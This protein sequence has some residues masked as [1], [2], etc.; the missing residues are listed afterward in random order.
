MAMVE[1]DRL[2]QAAEVE[3]KEAAARL[4]QA[5][6]MQADSEAAR[7]RMERAIA[8]A[9]EAR[10]EAE[11]TKRDSLHALRSLEAQI[12]ESRDRPAVVIQLNNGRIHDDGDRATL[13]KRGRVRGRRGG[14]S[15][16]RPVDV[17]LPDAGGAQG[18]H[19]PRASRGKAPAA[20]A[21]D[22]SRAAAALTPASSEAEL[23]QCAPHVRHRMG[24]E[25][26]DG[27]RQH[28]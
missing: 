10:R 11:R 7:T 6:A 5:N 9:G 13:E 26:I 25:H 16:A 28:G 23:L 15:C 18:G 27:V 20:A 17:G 21:S 12:E 2:R 14:I 4:Q 22:C 3:S 19:S 1:A 24:G 8:E